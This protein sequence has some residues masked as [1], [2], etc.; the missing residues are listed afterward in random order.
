MV[1]VFG[2]DARILQVLVDQLGVFLV[3]LLRRR[4]SSGLGRG[5]L[6]FLALREGRFY[7][8][9][10]SES[11]QQ[12]CTPKRGEAKSHKRHSFLRGSPD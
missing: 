6:T 8:G 10:G 7:D 4:W 12:Q 9:A 11:A 2:G 5:G 3:H 1:H